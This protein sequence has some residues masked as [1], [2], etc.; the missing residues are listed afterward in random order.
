MSDRTRELR[1]EEQQ[2]LADE[3]R[4]AARAALRRS[5]APTLDALAHALLR[6]EVLERADIDR[7]MDGASAPSAGRAPGCAW[8]RPR[9]PRRLSR[10]RRRSGPQRAGR[11]D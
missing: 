1:D 7:I 9:A 5:T 11:A 2:H 4:R 10:G 3:A 6:H 8:L